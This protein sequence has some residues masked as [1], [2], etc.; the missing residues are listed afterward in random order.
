MIIFKISGTV[1]N[2]CVGGGGGGQDFKEGGGGGGRGLLNYF[3]VNFFN[4]R[5]F[6]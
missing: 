4:C 1:C 2:V 5:I 3:N 6:I